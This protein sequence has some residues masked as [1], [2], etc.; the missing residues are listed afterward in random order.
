MGFRRRE[1]LALTQNLSFIIKLSKILSTHNTNLVQTEIPTSGAGRSGLLW[2]R[3]CQAQ[4]PRVP[5]GGDNNNNINN[6]NNNNL[7]VVRAALDTEDGG[8]CDQAVRTAVARV[9]YLTQHR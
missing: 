5:R 8:Q 2:T 6:N 9:Q 4:L 1:K 7:E 3:Q